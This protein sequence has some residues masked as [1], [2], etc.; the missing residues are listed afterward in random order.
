MLTLA[1]LVVIG[2]VAL[3][4]PPPARESHASA[5]TDFAL[6]QAVRDQLAGGASYYPAM[7]QELSARGY[8]TDR[9]FNWRPPFYLRLLAAGPMSLW[10]GVLALLL[11][12]LLAATPIALRD[13][14]RRA[15]ATGTALQLGVVLVYLAPT[16]VLLGDTWAGVLI[17]LSAVLYARERFRLAAGTALVALL[18]REL[19]APYCV[20]AACLAAWRRR[21]DELLVW[22]AGAAAYAAYY[23]WHAARVWAQEVPPHAARHSDWLQF[24]GMSFLQATVRWMGWAFVVPD[25]GVALAIVLI[26]AGIASPSAPPHVRAGSA[27]YVALFLV[28]GQPFNHYWGLIAGPV[29]ALACGPGLVAISDAGRT[30]MAGRSSGRR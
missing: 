10:R 30:T 22:V 26:G 8:P 19:A 20:A 14:G 11:I 25:A 13:L 2:A 17:G 7:A 12:G 1:A 5:R 27:A 23:G 15:V 21:R 9:V 16:L 24:G 18:F 3:L 28:A 29:W 4:W 6:F